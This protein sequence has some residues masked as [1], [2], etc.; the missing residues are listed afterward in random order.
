MDAPEEL[1]VPLTVVSSKT[2]KV[3]DS[4][5]A[6]GNP[7]G[8]Q[9][10]LT[11]GTVSQMD[12]AIQTDT[13]TSYE[14][15]NMIQISTPINPGNSGGPLLDSQGRVVGI[16]AAIVSDSNDVGFAVP[17]D[18]ILNEIQDRVTKGSYSHPYIGLSG[19]PLDYLISTAAGLNT[20]RGVLV[21]SVVA[22]SP[23]AA[24]GLIGGTKTVTVAGET[25][26]I[27]G[28]V[29]LQ[30]DDLPVRTMDGLLSYLEESTV[31]GETIDLTI[32]RGGETLTLS[33][34]LGSRG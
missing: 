19:T 30:V 7:Y 14:L 23:A 5:V 4:V 27:G 12:R 21:Q 32:M 2:V 29:I 25:V 31:P 6:I 26:K 3:G 8:L 34:V 16:T 9:S 10:T 22:G 17:S 1:L 33:V 24:A 20:T 15:A 28:D 11:S 13:T 18:A